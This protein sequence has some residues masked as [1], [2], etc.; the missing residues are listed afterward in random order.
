MQKDTATWAQSTVHGRGAGS[1]VG[2]W[3]RTRRARDVLRAVVTYALLIPGALMFL[4][5]FLWMLS[6]ALKTKQ[7]VF[8][9]PPVWI[10][11]PL[12][13]SNFAEA[14]TTMPFNLYLFNSLMTTGNNVIG[15]LVSSVL[16]AYGFSRL[17]ARGREALFLLVL[18]TMMVPNSITL[19]PQYVMFSRLKWTNSF[20]PLLIPPWFGWPFF[21]FLL[22]Q[23]FLTI[24][25]DLDDAARIDGCSTWGILFRILLPLAKP[26]LASVSIFAF[27]GGWNN[28]MGPLVYLHD[29]DLYTIALALRHFHVEYE[30]VAY[31]LMMA[32]AVLTVTPIILLF[33]FA[34]RTFIQGIAM[35]GIKG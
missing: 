11:D 30:T 1:R 22:R 16:A 20:W 6:T 5:P 34:Q 26:A 25:K 31:E 23:F 17:R 32:V 33:F 2:A 27:I 13:W 3:F 35:T 14:W 24:P 4:L 19:L 18:A 15:N 10:P 21:I 12:M 8:A 7:Q 28:F 29:P 9:Y